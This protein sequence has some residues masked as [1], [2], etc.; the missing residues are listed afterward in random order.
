MAASRDLLAV[1]P[2]PIVPVVDGASLRVSELL[3]ELTAFWDVRLV[4]PRPR[5]DEDILG[6]LGLQSFIPVTV[7]EK[8]TYLPFQY[9]TRP[10]IEAVRSELA[11]QRPSAVLLWWGSQFLGLEIP[12]LPPVVADR[13]DS[14]SLIAWRALRTWR[15]LGT[16]LSRLNTFRSTLSYE[17]RVAPVAHATVVVGEDD[18]RWLRRFGR[19][20][21][22]HVIPNGVRVDEAGEEYPKSRSPTIVFSGV[23]GY[24]PNIDAARYFSEEVWPLV[25]RSVAE[26]R[27]IIA[28]RGPTGEVQRLSLLDGV[29]VTGEIPDMR[30]LLAGAWVSVAPMRRGS[31]IKNKVLEAWA[32][33]TPVVM[34][35]L[36]T[37]G[38]EAA[39]EFREFV[40]DDPASMAGAVVGILE[41]DAAERRRL[42][43][44]VAEAAT[45]QSWT[46]A[47][48]R[49]GDLI[50]AARADES[51]AA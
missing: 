26:A 41:S 33:G 1:A 45:R 28:G 17:R 12:D 44:A 37:N 51:D 31:G 50:E 20:R 23:M 38:L 29:E 27:F 30:A 47:A 34:S 39:S 48:L 9:D 42:G 6:D 14:A 3:R 11:R 24:E 4:A 49:I 36:A 8:V 21:N 32:M 46:T 10:L 16:W 22:V 19:T 7:A 2:F 25:R 35:S 18:A 43:R 15:D 13:V 40:A 5:G